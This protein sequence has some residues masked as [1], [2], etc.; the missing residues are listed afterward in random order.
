MDVRKS[1][2]QNEIITEYLLPEKIVCSEACED[3]EF[4]LNESP[5]QVALLS[6][7][8]YM[9]IKKGGYMVLDFGAEIQGGIKICVF[10]AEKD[11]NMR[12]VFGESVSEAMSDI[13]YKKASNDHSIRDIVMPITNWSTFRYGNTGFRFVKLEAKE[14][15]IKISG[16]QAAFEHRD[17]EYKG[18]FECDDERINEIWKMGAYTVYLNMQEYLLDGIKR[19]RCVWVGD[20][21]PEVS[22]I[23]SVFG[24]NEIIRKSLNFVRDNTGAGK[25]MIMPSYNLW[26]LIIQYDYYMYTGNYEYL[27][28]NKEYI[29]KMCE[30]VLAKVNDDGTHNI[31]GKFVEWTSW[32]TEYTDAGFQAILKIGLETAGKLCALLGEKDFEARCIEA[33]MQAK[34]HI[35]PY[36]GNKQV[37][38]M[39]SLAEMVDCEKISNEVIKPGGAQGFSTFWGFYALKALAKSSDIDAALEIIRTYWGKMIDMG[40]TTFWEDFDIGWTENATRIDE[41]L[42]DGKVDIHGDC[43]EDCC[44]GLRQSLCHGWASGPTPFLMEYVAGIK[45]MEPGCRVMEINPKLGNLKWIKVKYPTPLGLVTVEAK[46]V[47]GITEKVISAPE[48]IKIL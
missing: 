48:G 15:D 25:W 43:G 9:I 7:M 35:Y 26:W 5:G 29:L 45:I 19:D 2:I 40:A 32:G 16:I 18:D 23:L 33:A 41:P 6:D 20:M 3:V 34:N 14:S 47:N 30:S 28:E 22:T 1:K 4:I 24:D 38:A 12:I 36:K 44:E 31:E 42:K 37:S 17:L 39:L 11:S 21:H 46:Q 27:L 8:K 10:E 13:G